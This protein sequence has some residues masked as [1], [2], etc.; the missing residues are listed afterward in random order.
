MGVCDCGTVWHEAWHSEGPRWAECSATAISTFLVIF[1]QRVPYFN[2]ALVPTIYV[3]GP[4]HQ[5]VFTKRCSSP[6][7]QKRTMLT[8]TTWT[9]VSGEGLRGCGQ[10]GEEATPGEFEALNLGMW[11]ARGD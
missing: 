7:I 9:A 5:S 4:V 6:M 11:R 8:G 1:Q 3:T 2:F 10:G